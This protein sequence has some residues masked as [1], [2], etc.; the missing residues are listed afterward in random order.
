MFFWFRADASFEIGTGHVMRCLTLAN[1]LRDRGCKCHFVCRD[2]PGN[3]SELIREHGHAIHLLASD[4]EGGGKSSTWVDAPNHANWLRTDWKSDAAETL[5]EIGENIVDWLI[6]DHYALD[7]QWEL[8]LR[9]KCSQIMVIDDLADRLHDCD[10]LLDQNLIAGRDLLYQN[11]V[12]PTCRLMLGP[13]Y[14]LLQPEYA[15]LHARTPLRE[16]VVNNILVYFGGAD[17]DNLSSMAVSAFL[18]LQRKDLT[19]DLVINPAGTHADMIRRQVLECPSVTIHNTLSS[20]A[21]LMV[22]A[23]LAIGAGGT[24]SWER[25]CLGLPSVVI[26]LAENQVLIAAELDKLGVIRWLGD[27][28]QVRETDLVKELTTVITEGLHPSWSERCSQIVDGR[29]AERVCAALMLDASRPLLARLA[30]LEDEALVREW[31]SSNET[32]IKIANFRKRLRNLDGCRLYIL[33]ADGGFAVG[34]VCFE[35]LNNAW[36]ISV[37]LNPLACGR[38]L[39]ITILQTAMR[40]FRKDI[41]IA[42]VFGP[43]Q[44][45]DNL[46]FSKIGASTHEPIELKKLSIAI[47]SDAASWIN[48]SVSELVIEWLR[49]GH[50]VT[51]A[52]SADELPGGDICFYLSYGRIV[53][54][55]TRAR[56][57]H[58]LVV[59]ASDL[60][61]GRGWSPA[62]W[63]ILEGADRI[64]VTLL[65]AGDLVDAGPV[66]MQEW[67]ELDGSEL[68]DDWRG[69]LAKKTADLTRAFVSRYP[70]VLDAARNQAGEPS[71]YP[72]RRAKDSALDPN[73]TL[74]EQINLMRIVDNENYPAFF[75]HNGNEFVLEI[76]RR[77]AP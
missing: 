23:D 44:D 37:T 18:S 6:V 25:S 13:K 73:K 2:L 54:V 8:R 67:I 21:R 16:G 33:E 71:T 28:S 46:Q 77:K 74:V 20:L 4:D 75:I 3:L 63:L 61:K 62:S 11:K 9:I 38:K 66:Y 40:A 72:R 68:I 56:Y 31:A 39:G 55:K 45:F 5:A 35:Y 42:L 1:A 60:P 41:A 43:I 36:Q 48:N 10:L 58:N 24:T 30:N 49:T 32:E 59:H 64:P 53:D 50:S 65:G 7:A 47:C 27:K 69:Q 19:L 70:E 51:W 15:E 29:G 22:K 52:H 34:Q 17:N 14:A 57:L 76:S 26:T 12:S